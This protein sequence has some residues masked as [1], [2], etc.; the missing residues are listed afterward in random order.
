[1]R[2][3]C[4]TLLF[5]LSSLALA[6]A[7]GDGVPDDTDNC[8]SVAN[9]DQLDTDSDGVGDVCDDDDD[10]DGVV[11]E[12]DA[13]PLNLFETID[14]DGDGVGDNSDED[15]DNDGIDDFEDVFPLNALEYQ[16]T[17]SDGTGDNADSDDD[18]DGWL[19]SEDNCPVI[20][21]AG[22][23]DLDQDG[24]GDP[25]DT[26]PNDSRRSK[27]CAA[28]QSIR[29]ETQQEVN[30][31][32][33][34]YAD[35][36]VV[37]NIGIYDFGLNSN[38]IT[39]L[40]GLESI[41]WVQ[42]QVNISAPELTNIKGLQN[43]RVV[44]N[45]SFSDS[46]LA[47]F[48]G[49]DSLETALL[50]SVYNSPSFVSLQGLDKLS[51]LGG[52]IIRNTSIR[53]LDG[54][55]NATF[56]LGISS[57][58]YQN[59][60]ITISLEDNNELEDCSTLGPVL[61][62]PKYPRLKKELLSE[63]IEVIFSNNGDIID[64]NTCLLQYGE[65]ITADEDTDGDGVVDSLDEDNDGDGVKDEDDFHPWDSS[66]QLDSDRDSIGDNA[67]L[68]DDNDR[69]QDVDDAF[70]F[71][72]RESSD[73]DQDGIG[74]F[75]DPDD[76]NNG[77]LDVDEDA[78]GDS[79]P[80]YWEAK[81]GLDPLVANDPLR[82]HDED[83][84][85]LKE[86]F[87]L[88][89][90]PFESDSDFDGLPDVWERDNNR[91]PTLTDYKMIGDGGTAC[92]L[93]DSNVTCWGDGN[94]S[95][96]KYPFPNGL[97][98]HAIAHGLGHVCLAAGENA[99][100][101]CTFD[102]QMPSG[103]EPPE[104]AGVIKLWG[105]SHAMCAETVE[106]LICWGSDYSKDVW[107]KVPP[108]IRSVDRLEFWIDKACALS[109]KKIIC[110]GSDQFESS[111]WFSQIQSAVNARELAL[112]W[113]HGCF[114]DDDG[115]KCFG[116][117]GLNS[118]EL[119]PP[120]LENPRDLTANAGYSCAL[121]DDQ[122]FCWGE[123]NS[124]SGMQTDITITP[125]LKN[126]HKIEAVGR[127]ACAL[128]DR[129]FD[130]WGWRKGSVHE[131]APSDLL[132]DPD[133]DGYSNQDGQDA[134]PLDATEHR[135]FDLDGAGDNTDN[136][137]ALANSNQQD[138]DDDGV[139]NVC[140]SDADGDSLSNAK[141]DDDDNDGVTD[142]QDGFPLD[143]DESLD[144][145]SDGTGNNADTDDDGDG[146]LDA[147]DAFPLDATEAL[148]TDADGTGN[149]SDTDDDNDGVEDTSDA[150]PLDAS[151][152]ADSDSD[153]VGDNSD[154]F[155]DDATESL[156]SD[157]DS[158]GDNADNCPS[159]SNT[160]QLNTDGDTEGD[161]CDSDDDNDGFSDD[162]EELDGTNPK[163]RFSC[164]SGCFSFDVDENLEAQPL[165]DGLL[166]I[167]HLF[168]FSGDSLISG[169]VSGGASRDGS[170]AIASYLTDADSELD[171]D[172]DGE[173]KPLTD[174]LLLIRYLFGFSGDSL[175]SGAIGDGAERD[176]AE[177][178]EAYIKERVPVQQ[179]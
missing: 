137:P 40:D 147:S 142:S 95:I 14:S 131:K 125:T 66:E 144:T 175:I 150:F 33:V 101:V 55:A 53:N 132:V 57:G 88:G 12:E 110:W 140:D 82:D 35:C 44:Y 179:V 84:L 68:D 115:L 62:W 123:N 120:E 93:T 126:I 38:R 108:F 111:N 73:L 160:N 49:M 134:F 104:I 145:D 1:M 78:D 58:Y 56:E 30:D 86:E 153:G 109:E 98:P 117:A 156:D 52:I 162:Q 170:D 76:D 149:N 81:Y 173:S 51:E 5:S 70:P 69:V 36:D 34:T 168:G 139:G 138:S 146:V 129:G 24:V 113:N 16:D 94:Y 67:D 171:I 63:K 60:Q 121:D 85:G 161:A 152:T 87:L 178:V 116:E 92:A 89:T 27:L 141:D 96:R 124:G 43:L 136:C 15:D 169:A 26:W 47:T 133:R 118:G 6:G 61:G 100:L 9:S 50:L 154:A 122:V 39:N 106:G 143:P 163:S 3:L 32:S 8:P 105:D 17:D 97:K 11:D 54:I 46:K 90:S 151:E 59:G 119:S 83:N 148:D 41:K 165:T 127:H 99:N 2:L 28:G 77:I 155:P 7:D 71:D 103:Y 176:T 25:C 177:E 172:G 135:D 102:T 91:N 164:R 13:F 42:S 23:Q 114:I 45:L 64:W 18:G 167:R 159:L 37:A 48:E 4:L 158:V 72:P 128:S 75:S 79:L 10:G 19:D 21:N 130:C 74:D 29:L 65:K 174:G 107:S 112:S 22:Q 31:F 80:D 157:N 20:A 166:V